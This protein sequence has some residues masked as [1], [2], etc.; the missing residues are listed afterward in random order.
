MLRKKQKAQAMTEF[1]IILP[2]LLLLLLGIIE[3]GR[4]IW[5]Y[6]TVQQAARQAARF[7]V[8]GRPFLDSNIDLTDPGQLSICMAANGS[9]EPDPFAPGV[10][11]WLCDPDD[12]VEAIKRVALDRGRTLNVSQECDD[13][14]EFVGDCSQRPGAFGVLIRGQVVTGTNQVISDPPIVDHPGT[15]GLNI[16]VST[17][18]NIEMI[19][20]VYNVVMGGNYLT[21]RGAVLMQNEGLDGTLGIEP[22]P[23]IAAINP[24]NAQNIP[25]GGLIPSLKSLNGVVF[26]PSQTIQVELKGHDTDQDPYEVYLFNIT[27]G[28]S[29][30]I[31]ANVTTDG[32]HEATVNCPLSGL[33]EG[34][35]YLF[36]ALPGNP[37]NHLAEGDQIEIIISTVPTIWF[38]EGG[39]NVWAANTITELELVEHQQSAGPNYDVFLFHPT[40]TDFNSPLRQIGD[41]IA[42]N[43][44]PFNWTVDDV[45]NDYGLARCNLRSG[46]PCIIRSYK[47]GVFAVAPN[48]YIAETQVYINQPRIKL[49]PDVQPYSQGQ[50][51]RVF[52]EDHTPGKS[53]DVVIPDGPFGSQLMGP[54]LGVNTFGDSSFPVSWV[55]PGACA[56]AGSW[57]NGFYD[58]TSNT[59]DDSLVAGVK[60]AEMK[61]V[62]FKEPPDPFILVDGGN[63]WPA[64]SL[65]TI[66]VHKHLQNTPHYLEFNGV[67][68]P[69]GQA[70]DTFDTGDCGFA[71]VEYTIPLATAPGVYKVRSFLEDG[72]LQAEYDVLVNLVPLIEVVEGNTALPNSKITI[73]LT[74]HRPNTGYR[75]VFDELD[76]LA[77]PPNCPTTCKVLFEILTDDNGAAEIVY[78]LTNLPISPGPNMTDVNNYGI[79]FDLF[80]QN[81]ENKQVAATTQLA[82]LGADLVVTQVQFPPANQIQMNGMT[83]VSVTV[84]NISPVPINGYFDVDLYFNPTPIN[85]SYYKG[86]NFPGD[87]KYWKNS[88]AA[89]GQSGDTFVI[90]DTFFVGEYGLQTLHGFADTSNY[91]REGETSGLIANAN[92]LLANSVNVR[93]NTPN[94]T[95][96]AFGSLPAGWSSQ[97]YGNANVGGGASISSNRLRL[98]SDGSSN[99]QANDTSGGEFLYYQATPA[100]S[101]TLA[102]DVIVQV[103]DVE[104]V[105]SWA[106]AGIEIR[107]SITNTTSP[108]IVLAV[109]RENGGS[110]HVI[111]PAFR[112]GGGNGMNWAPPNDTF[113]LNNHEINFSNGPVWLRVERQPGS[114]TFNYYYRQIA[115]PAT[116]PTDPT[117]AATWW[118]APVSSI[119]VN[120]MNE[121]LYVGLFNS[122]YNN[123]TDGDALL[124]NFTLIDGST[125]AVAQGAGEA[126]EILPPGL[127]LCAD[128]ILDQSFESNPT[129]W[130]RDFSIGVNVVPGQA[131][132]GN[133]KMRAP[134][135]PG[136]STQPW[137][138]QQFIMND[139]VISTTTTFNLSLAR[140]VDNQ[141]DN[142]SADIFYAIVT[143]NPGNIATAI[144][145]RVTTPTV[146]ATGAT[147]PDPYDPTKWDEISL[148]LPIINRSTLESLANQQLYLY[149]YN[150][151]NAVA[152]TC[153]GGLGR[154]DTNYF[155]DD[156]SLAPC[157][158]QPLPQN[159]STR[160]TGELTLNFSGGAVQ[161]LPYVKVW[162]YAQNGAVFETVTLPDGRYNFFNLPATPGGVEYVIFSQYHLINNMV[163]PPQIETLTDDA[164]TTLIQNVHTNTT[165]QQVNLDLFTLDPIP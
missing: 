86:Y 80:S 125:C 91:V 93:C 135:F 72:T 68:V 141:G 54:T 42:W 123:G 29:H 14:G 95:Q 17:F 12:R 98:R 59:R 100:I 23:P 46:T 160:L 16:E 108:R 150:N 71:A 11:P 64:G 147:G 24:D 163:D 57:P 151:S 48:D 156:V 31:C 134:T 7:A 102:F 65:I 36:S 1:A 138:Y 107:N 52:L 62:E 143:T 165:P 131:H 109:A 159:I 35:Y 89:A 4:V 149:L 127:T 88:V 69:T 60:I 161:K 61:D 76:N 37:G 40:D 133:R 113:F 22:P 78:D 21:L 47:D 75:V 55:I 85:P 18:Y 56:G 105:G 122:P 84:K 19:T 153:P 58:I 81:T 2:L 82:L 144:A 77:D 115:D 79:F 41:N 110:N 118:G 25:P 39:Q 44:G 13:P 10:Q 20:P 34:T 87:V 154:C 74:N 94:I 51:L 117:A 119:T 8:T 120:E 99:W 5:A 43:A 66:E 145:N 112:T 130:Q 126:E 162:A 53:Y 63:E 83:P 26:Q 146:V 92:N 111:Q 32:N 97:W 101:T 142:D 6:I 30:R 45:E 9:Q 90:T 155:F 129:L 104:K 103:I 116:P 96:H 33:D 38:A 148:S 70:G 164:R 132:S 139:W 106:K 136:F 114:N 67:R 157:T 50:T 28:T 124:D 152:G 73:R 140:N 49:V 27:T 158:T 128:P 15:P 121:A 137:F 3:A